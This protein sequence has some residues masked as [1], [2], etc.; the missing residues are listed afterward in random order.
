MIHWGINF[1][2]KEIKE[3]RKNFYGL[4]EP[5]QKDSLTEEEKREF[6][7][8]EESLKKTKENINRLERYRYHD[9]DDLDYKGIRQIE[10]L[11]N[12]INDDYYKP[13]KIKGAFNNNYIEY[14]RKGD[15]DKILS[16]KE[17]LYMIIP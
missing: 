2:K 16:V 1:Q 3:I 9:N 11:F 10:N 12:E 14:E 13:I 8:V 15:K 6:K 4:K 17:Y 5:E 7:R